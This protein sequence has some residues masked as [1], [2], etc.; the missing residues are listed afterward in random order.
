MIIDKMPA[1][2]DMDRLVA[3]TFDLPFDFYSTDI[4]AAWT[5]ALKVVSEHDDWQL[6][7][8]YDGDGVG[9]VF[10]ESGAG[11]VQHG[12]GSAKHGEIA[13]AICRAALRA[14][15]IKEVP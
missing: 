5:V 2:R 1:G 11:Y 3:R 12:G 7:I 15:G 10:F 8:N 9:V 4:A 6:G 14:V 13:L